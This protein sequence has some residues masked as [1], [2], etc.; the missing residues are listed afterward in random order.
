MEP[1]R[2]REIVEAS[3]PILML[4]TV[5]LLGFA[6]LFPFLPAILWGIVL[7]VALE[8]THLWFK[9]RLGGNN[10]AATIAILVLL[11]VIL[12]VPI[13]FL[14]RS[15]ISFVPEGIRWFNNI[16]LPPEETVAAKLRWTEDVWERMMYDLATI[17]AHY[18]EE[19]R[20]LSFWALDEGRLLGAF[21]VEFTIGVLI[22]AVFMHRA[23]L[24]SA[25]VQRALRL[26]GGETA[27]RLGRHAVAT[28]RSSV[29]GLLGSAAVQAALVSV[30][31]WIADIPHWPL[32]S[33]ATFILAMIQIGPVLVWAPAAAW[34]WWVD[35][36]WMAA[37]VVAWGIFVVGLS[38]NVVRT[39]IV[40]RGTEMPA[41]LAF[42]GALGGLLTWGI[43]GIFVGP[44]IL[45]VCHQLVVQWME[46]QRE[47]AEDAAS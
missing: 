20:A 41:L 42:L 31:F 15:M 27:E 35:Q 5:F 4:A 17:R 43:V 16:S 28:V 7:S 6:A 44:V 2:N 8:P 23:D 14:S 40:S 38:D 3:L 21:V 10:T 37:F 32:L 29:L 34:L 30:A 9:R 47:E 46:I 26:I 11:V 18:D 45:A 25:S 22:A 12:V 33:L 39:V 36:P 19:I 1:N 13:V 24:S